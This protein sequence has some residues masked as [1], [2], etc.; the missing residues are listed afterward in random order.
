M[1]NNNFIKFPKQYETTKNY[2]AGNQQ[3][4]RIFR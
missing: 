3:R 1:Q 2:Q 4:D